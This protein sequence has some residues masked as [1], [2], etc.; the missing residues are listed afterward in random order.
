MRQSSEEE[1]SDEGALLELDKEKRA[2]VLI[3]ASVLIFKLIV[4]AGASKVHQ[5][6]SLG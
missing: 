3:D 5:Q 1:V 4:H 2:A 6:D